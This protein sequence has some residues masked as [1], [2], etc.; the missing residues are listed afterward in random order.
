VPEHV[1][2]E[3]QVRLARAVGR[4]TSLDLAFSGRSRPPAG[5][6]CS[7][8]GSPVTRWSGCRSRSERAPAGR[9]PYRPTTSTSTRI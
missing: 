4:H 6:G 3:L 5:P 7:G 8:P 2:P 9:G 1:L